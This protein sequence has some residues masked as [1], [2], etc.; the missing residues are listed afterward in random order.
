MPRLP[1][2][3][4]EGGCYH[5]VLRGNH[6]ESIFS[7][8]A[9]RSILNEYVAESM[10]KYAARIHAYCWMTN[11]LHALIQIGQQPLGLVVKRFAMRYSRHRHR[12]LR[13]TGHLFERRYKAWL[14]DAD[15]Y[16][17]ALLQYIHRNP[18]EARVVS[19]A[20]E[21]P[22]SSHRAYLGI[23][24][25]PWLTTEFGL[26]F[27]ANTIETARIKYKAVIDNTSIGTATRLEPALLPSD[28]H[29][30]F[31]RLAS[32]ATHQTA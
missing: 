2:L 9:D 16:F 17:I 19:T 26:G 30:S 8:S 11:H 7:T 28:R 24:M 12:Q 21:Y 27:F 22:W 18:V 23:E 32:A 1:R 20:D 31:R 10:E 5:V 4:V 25:V 15:T 14:V 13:T 3:H 6:R 29:R